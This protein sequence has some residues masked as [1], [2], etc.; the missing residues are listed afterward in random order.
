MSLGENLQFYRKKE[1]ITQEQL[2][3][4]LEVSRQTVSKWE[5]GTT[6]PEM[7]KIIQ[8]CEMF[9]CSMDILLRGDAKEHLKED[10]V[11]YDKN[12]NQF[13][14][15]LCIGIGLVLL[16][17]AF[18]QFGS[19]F[20]MHESILN[21]I[22]ML[23]ALVAIIDFVITGMQK[24]YF[25][26]KNPFVQAIYPEEVL[27]RF[28]KRFPIFV[29]CGVGLIIGGLIVEQVLEHMLKDTAAFIGRDFATA[30]FMLFVTAGVVILVIGGTQKEK[31]DI[32]AYNKKHSP[33]DE[34]VKN[35]KMI[36]TACAVIMLITTGVYLVFGLG[37]ARWE[38][39]P[40]VYAVGGLLCG[41]VVL[42]IKGIEW[43]K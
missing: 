28:E 13:T 3:E 34:D 10:T 35:N 17:V 8:L 33:D 21:G 43:K 41:V 29:G 27:E 26:K 42:L 24:E 37:M 19:A 39:A 6:F 25:E 14:L 18:Y 16:G 31:Y 4:K 23:F 12:M 30:V 15:R 40:V 5:A 22:F 2:A 7:D 11:D 1:N 20:R 9:S 36:G 38:I 32:E